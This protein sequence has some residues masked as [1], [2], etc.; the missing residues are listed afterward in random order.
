[1]NAINVNIISILLMIWTIFL[2]A[3][4]MQLYQR[5][6]IFFSLSCL[7]IVAL[8]LLEII[9][10]R[11]I[12]INSYDFIFLR[13]VVNAVGFSITPLGIIFLILF[14][15]YEIDKKVK[16]W[17]IVLFWTPFMICVICSILSIWFPIIF[18]FDGLTYQ[19]KAFFFI[20]SLTSLTYL[21]LLLVVVKLKHRSY[22]N[23]EFGFL[24]ISI[25]IG[26]ISFFI[27]ILIKNVFLIWSS[28]S[29]SLI[30][31][32]SLMQESRLQYD[33][34]TGM[35]NRNLFQ[36]DISALENTIKMGIVI[37]DLNSLK[38]VND[39]YGHLVGDKIIIDTSKIIQETFNQ[40]YCYR[41]GGDEFVVLLKKT[42]KDDAKVLME[43]F[44]KAIHEYNK[45]HELNIDV[46][47]GCAFRNQTQG[48]SVMDVFKKADD[49]MYKMKETR[50]F[51]KK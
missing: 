35:K 30:I 50:K 40:D 23:T 17:I 26:A 6:A 29:V 13:K 10:N 32:Y 43:E 19:R 41:I 31:Y 1:M 44:S 25:F 34:M 4:N 33:S 16:K 7:V 38:Y 28:Y 49:N 22:K 46:S 21:I 11:L 51:Y 20:P 36:K 15:Y 2:I 12:D 42:K 18:S 48:E 47:Y 5:K 24:C 3:R 45:T 8:L 39:N 9:E 27:Q 14:N 37:F